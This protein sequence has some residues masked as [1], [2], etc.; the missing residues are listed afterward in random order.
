MHGKFLM[1]LLIIII[2]TRRGNMLF[3]YSLGIVK[4]KGGFDF[5]SGIETVFAHS[6]RHGN[7][8]EKTRR[9]KRVGCVGRVAI[10]EMGRTSESSAKIS[11]SIVDENE[12]AVG[13]DGSR[14]C[15]KTTARGS[16]KIN[17]QR[18]VFVYEKDETF[19]TGSNGGNI[20]VGT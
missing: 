3:I 8:T 5:Q 4:K 13:T 11:T 10:V 9:G 17:A 12:S 15:E 7:R 16:S 1:S 20:F 6:I 2:T 18:N 14:G 19:E